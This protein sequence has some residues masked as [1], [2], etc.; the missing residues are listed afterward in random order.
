VASTVVFGGAP[1]VLPSGRS[2][3]RGHAQA[4][5]YRLAHDGRYARP[6]RD[7]CLAPSV[8]LPVRRAAKRTLRGFLCIAHKFDGGTVPSATV[9]LPYATVA[10]TVG[11]ED[12]GVGVN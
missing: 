3:R 4:P 7:T 8:L 10:V 11:Y 6:Y 12:I 2:D 1:S 9:P 5:D